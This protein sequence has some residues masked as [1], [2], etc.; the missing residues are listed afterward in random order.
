VVAHR[1]ST[2]RTADLIVAIEEGH[3]KEKGT[4]TELMAKN[5][6]YHSLVMR[7]TQGKFA[8][9]EGETTEVIPTYDEANGEADAIDTINLDDAKANQSIQVKEDK[10][11]EE[12]P[13]I[14]I[15]RLIKRNSPEWFYILVGVLASSAMGATMPIYSILFGEV[16][17]VLAYAD[18]QKARDDSI[19]YSLMFC[20]LALYS[21]IVMLLQGW[22]FA[23]SGE[24]LTQRLRKDTFKAMLKQEMGWYDMPENNTGALCARLSGDAAKVQGATGARVGSVL[25][26][27]AGIIIAIGLGLY[28]NW[29]LGLVCTVFFPLMIGATMAEMMIVQGVDTVEKVAFETSAKVKHFHLI[30]HSN[31]HISAGR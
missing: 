2:I 22:F 6:L 18:T 10:E 21:L 29:K 3:V 19:K 8:E 1:L 15:S 5:G 17:G 31:Q 24:N 20:G 27:V 11:K 30:A 26:G 25:Q 28:Y 4:H 7:Q 23:I 9:E 13:K 14:Q 12:L 16:L